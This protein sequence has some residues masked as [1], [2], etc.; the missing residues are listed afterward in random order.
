MKRSKFWSAV[1]CHGRR[2]KGESGE[3]LEGAPDAVLRADDGGV[4][5]DDVSAGDRVR[6]RCVGVDGPRVEV[7][8][9]EVLRAEGPFREIRVQELSNGHTTR[10]RRPVAR[11]HLCLLF[12]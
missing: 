1:S 4:A 7:R 5:G 6:R 9:R 11:H 12:V 8:V 3:D 10:L 2:R